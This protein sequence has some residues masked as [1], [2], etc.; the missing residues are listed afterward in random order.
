MHRELA[1]QPVFSV[2]LC[3]LGGGVPG[4]VISPRLLQI[5]GY[6]RAPQSFGQIRESTDLW[7]TVHRPLLGGL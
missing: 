6:A 3:D 5:A 4:D 1:I 7:S 2:F